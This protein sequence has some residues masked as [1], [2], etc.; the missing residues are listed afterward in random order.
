M[1][2]MGSTTLRG[3]PS[4]RHR[5][6]GQGETLPRRAGSFTYSPAASF[7]GSDSFTNRASD[8]LLGSNG[9]TVAITVNHVNH[10]PVA[11]NDS[12][13][14]NEDSSPRRSAAHVPE[15]FTR[16]GI[17]ERSPTLDPAPPNLTPRGQRFMIA[18]GEDVRPPIRRSRSM[19]FL[20]LPVLLGLAVGLLVG[21]PPA[22]R[23][24]DD[25]KAAPGDTSTRV[26][27]MTIDQ[28][29]LH[30][31]YYR[32]GDGGGKKAPC[33]ILLH[34]I[35]SDST[36]DGWDQLARDLQKA[37]Y[38]VLTFDFRGHGD[39][40]A[41]GPGFW[42]DR[43]SPALAA[44]TEFNV[45]SCKTKVD[46]KKPRETISIKD[47]NKG[48]YPALVN[49]VAAAKAL[50]DRH[51]DDGECN[52][53]N[54]VLIGAED[55]ATVGALW[56]YADL[57]LYR[58]YPGYP[59]QR[60]PNPEGKDV[61]ACVWLSIS[62]Q[63]G[64]YRPSVKNW[65]EAA[66]KERKVPMAFLCGEK[67]PTVSFTRSCYQAVKPTKGTKAAKLTG[68]ILV[69]DSKLAGNALLGDDVT[70]EGK[71]PSREWIVN[72]Y[73]KA[74]RD[75]QTA[76]EWALREIDKTAFVWISPA[77]GLSLPAKSALEKTLGPIHLAP[78][79]H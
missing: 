58:I 19:R 79:L 69:K 76:P 38:A 68:E 41:V 72:Q 16:L 51:N 14:L 49:D 48:Y 7:G 78:F 22:A 61:A 74:V 36:R 8:G 18:G 26:K 44:L 55:G 33:A 23:A 24:A 5:P 54:L 50:L 29:E 71:V 11:N 43:S 15:L 34:K 2:V 28:V 65:L 67:D 70:V 1:Q 37:G 4:Y 3:A 6:A 30:G 77:S 64:S 45:R 60:A 66:G 20:P 27:F 35:E 57:S 46:L 21:G 9:A 63:L 42:N 12:Y 56:M 52:S 13:T 75:E 31:N 73:L 40:T 25:K 17:L 53:Q 39:S 47:F 62:P 10:P 32:P 59:S